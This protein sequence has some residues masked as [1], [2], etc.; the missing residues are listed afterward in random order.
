MACCLPTCAQGSSVHVTGNFG[1]GVFLGFLASPWCL[2][3]LGVLALLVISLVCTRLGSQRCASCWTRP[4]GAEV[5][6][7]IIF[8]TPGEFAEQHKKLPI[9]ILMRLVFLWFQAVYASFSEMAQSP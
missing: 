9:K 1:N 3:H 2:V 8:V 6:G 5:G 7:G 4:E